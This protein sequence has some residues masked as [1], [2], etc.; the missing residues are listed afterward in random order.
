MQRIARVPR[1]GIVLADLF[2][3]LDATAEF[4]RF[5]TAI[6]KAISAHGTDR[7]A[8]HLTVKVASWG[9]GTC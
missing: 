9:W 8:L 2:I 4:V 3:V 1:H 6:H 5:D 7:T